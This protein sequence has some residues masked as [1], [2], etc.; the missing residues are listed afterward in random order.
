MTTTIKK[1]FLL[2][3]RVISAKH[4]FAPGMGVGVVASQEVTFVLPENYSELLLASSIAQYSDALLCQEIDV[5]VKE[6][7]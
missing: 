3:V 1:T 7:V 6:I 2:S 4:E 5:D